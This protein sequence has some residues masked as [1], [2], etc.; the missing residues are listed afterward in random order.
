MSDSVEA[1]SKKLP[2]LRQDLET[3][4]RTLEGPLTEKQVMVPIT[5]KGFFSGTLKPSIK[6]GQEQV[7]VKM[8]SGN[9]VELDRSQAIAHLDGR[10]QSLLSPSVAVVIA[11]TNGKAKESLSS[12]EHSFPFFEIREE[13]DE[14]GKEVKAEAINVAKQLELLQKREGKDTNASSI[15]PTASADDEVIDEHPEKRKTMTDT[16]YEELSSRLD[17]LARLEEEAEA[18]KAENQASA[19]KLQSKGWSKGF[20]NAKPKKKKAKPKKEAHSTPGQPSSQG[21]KVAFQSQDQIREIPRVGERSTSELKSSPA[22]TTS[23]REIEPQVF[24]GVIRERPVDLGS[25]AADSPSKNSPARKKLSRF[26]QERLDQ[27]R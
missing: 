8:G 9:L 3:A 2:V 17:M 12:E 7:L 21:R 24:S 25:K 23:R 15:V 16:E 1:L 13:L 20:L 5:T 22:M 18:T 14:S 6:D 11:P 4:K 26:A 27:Q 19:K 10:I